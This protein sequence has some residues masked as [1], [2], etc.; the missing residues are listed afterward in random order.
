ME[1]NTMSASFELIG[2]NQSLNRGVL[3]AQKRA[4]RGTSGVSQQNHRFG[5][6]PAYLDLESGTTYLSRF[7]DGSL[8]PI[9]ILDGLPEEVVVRRDESGR[10]MQV[11]AS[12]IAG[13]VRDGRFYTRE[14][15][16]HALNS[17]GPDSLHVT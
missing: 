7:S 8:A 17:E 16:A 10:V 6:R 1:M 12:V 3:C 2:M 11:K 5:F 13:F 9:H 14:Q 15:A 4:F